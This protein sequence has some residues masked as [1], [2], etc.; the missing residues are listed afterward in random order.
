M[1]QGMNNTSKNDKGNDDSSGNCEKT[2]NQ[3][4]DLTKLLAKSIDFVIRTSYY[5][6]EY[7]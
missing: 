7:F 3:H 2:Q 4:Q 6:I 5:S 1:A